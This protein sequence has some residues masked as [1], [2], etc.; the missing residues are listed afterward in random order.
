[1]GVAG[2]GDGSGNALMVE[3]EAVVMG[4]QFGAFHVGVDRRE[5]VLASP[6]DRR[7]DGPGHERAQPVGPHHQAAADRQVGAVRP[8][9]LDPGD[10]RG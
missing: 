8:L 10:P 9:D 7:I 5:G 6:R 4:R 1:M 2:C 3:G